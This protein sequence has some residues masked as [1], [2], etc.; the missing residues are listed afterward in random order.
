MFLVTLSKK[1]TKMVDNLK[2]IHYLGKLL[3]FSNVLDF[4]LSLK[5]KKHVNGNLRLLIGK[6]FIFMLN[7]P[8]LNLFIARGI[9]MI[10]FVT[11]KK[12]CKLFFPCSIISEVEQPI[13]AAITMLVL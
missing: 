2:I 13:I 3:L 10:E 9:W 5:T 7:G 12:F 4:L 8:K 6:K 1:G 11:E